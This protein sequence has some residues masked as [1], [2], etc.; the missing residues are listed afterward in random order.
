MI[1]ARCGSRTILIG[2]KDCLG[3]HGLDEDLSR[4]S[5]V[6]EDLSRRSRVGRDGNESLEKISGGRKACK[7]DRRTTG[8]N[9]AEAWVE[10]NGTSQ[11]V[12]SQIPS[13]IL[14]M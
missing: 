12:F 1:N 9:A 3:G 13:S 6:G 14:I 7:N 5:R 8:A 11:Q 4:R 10:T 2:I